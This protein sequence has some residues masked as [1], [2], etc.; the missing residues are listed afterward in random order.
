[1]PYPVSFLKTIG[2]D[3]FVFDIITNLIFYVLFSFVMVIA[4]SSITNAGENIPRK[5]LFVGVAGCTFV[6]VVC[7]T[8][9]YVFISLVGK[10]YLISDDVFSIL[11]ILL[12]FLI[13][14]KIL[15][16]KNVNKKKLFIIV[17]SVS[18]V[19]LLICTYF[20][21]RYLNEI[22][23]IAEK[24]TLPV[25]ESIGLPDQPS[26]PTS[27]FNNLKYEHQVRCC[28][29]DV[30][31]ESAVLLGLY[32]S[33]SSRNVDN[34][35]RRNTILKMLIRFNA[36]FVALF[37]VCGLKFLA[38][39]Y[40]FLANTNIE[41]RY[42][43]TLVDSFEFEK[44]ATSILRATSYKGR[45]EIYSRTHGWLNYGD[46]KILNIYMDYD[47]N[48][49]STE[50]VMIGETEVTIVCTNQAIAY[51]KDGKPYAVLF[52]NVHKQGKDT[53]LLETC[54]TLLSNGRTDCFEYIG[55]YVRKYDPL[56]LDSYIARYA[57]G[58]FTDIEIEN[59][60]E[61]N[62]NFIINCAKDLLK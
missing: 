37:A 21:F 44:K 47:Y 13:T 19:A 1:M 60:G 7:D 24:Y 10:F 49:P 9:K 22:S 40:N 31:C 51:L 58:D 42:S 48:G 18:A 53:V 5:K 39:P 56:Y 27:I 32:F 61:I 62:P 6:Q 2:S 20:N 26:I 23:Y 45:K 35:D 12:L 14:A 57:H 25:L 33:T 15:Q 50:K 59:M 34:N 29:L 30:V 11:K 16:I 4:I 54:K 3:T 28:I 43:S 36:I 52:E 38:L 41:S 46:D 17:T 8:L 55:E